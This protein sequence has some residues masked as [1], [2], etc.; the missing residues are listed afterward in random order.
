MDEV[1]ISYNKS[2]VNLVDDYKKYG[3]VILKNVFEDD[4]IRS[5]RNEIKKHELDLEKNVHRNNNNL[6]DVLSYSN[7]SKALLNKKLINTIKQLLNSTPIYFGQSSFRW[8]EKPS[9]GFHN[10]ANNDNECPFQSEYP[11]LRIGIYFQ[12]HDQTSGGL[13]I[14]P[15][16]NSVWQPGRALLKKIIKHRYSF[17]NLFPQQYLKNIN[18]KTKAGDVVLWNLRTAHSGSAIRLKYFTNCSLSPLIENF[19]SKYLNFLV[20]PIGTERAV[21]FSTFGAESP[22]LNNFMKYAEDHEGL[23]IIFKNSNWNDLVIKEGFSLGLKLNNKLLD[24]FK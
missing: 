2:S 11:I 23:K 13:K 3:Y 4:E 19:I 24:K 6:K 12:D 21:I 18:V 22:Q 17:K 1:E 5:F 8:N 20:K 9:R 16:S 14:W 7:L 10:D 15:K